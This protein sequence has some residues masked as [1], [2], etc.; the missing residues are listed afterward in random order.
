MFKYFCKDSN[1]WEKYKKKRRF[2]LFFALTNCRL[3]NGGD[4]LARFWQS[5]G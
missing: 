4:T 1:K 3:L 2:L 5:M